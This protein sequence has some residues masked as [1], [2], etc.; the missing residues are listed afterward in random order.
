MR[1]T[2]ER[3]P[4]RP[5]NAPPVAP[6]PT[7]VAAPM[8]VDP[9]APHQEDTGPIATTQPA[10]WPQPADGPVAPRGDPFAPPPPGSSTIGARPVDLGRPQPVRLLLSLT[11]LVSLA[12]GAAV[13]VA[14]LFRGEPAPPALVVSTTPPGASVLL[15]GTPLPGSTPLMIS[16]GLVEGQSYALEVRLEGYSPWQATIVASPGTTT[17]EITLT[18]SAVTLHVETVPPG[19]AIS[20][21]GALVGSSPLD[22]P[23]LFMGQQLTVRATLPGYSPAQGVVV[24]AH[25][26]E[27]MALTLTAA[28]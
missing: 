1:R 20:I 19:A 13:G 21:N 16:S 7:L 10:P 25:T 9:F 8:P 2:E 15:D 11:F 5:L 27:R 4:T 12:V 28:P 14:W 23:N 3:A 17:Q 24:L 26:D 18:P 22:V 6:A